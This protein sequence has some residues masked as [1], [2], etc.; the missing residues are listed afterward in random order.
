MLE[1]KIMI[2]KL[3]ELRQKKG[4]S[5]QALADA[6]GVSQQSVNKYENHN[7]EPDIHTLIALADYF[8]TSVDYLIGH[9]EV[10]RKIEETTACDL[11]KEEAALLEKWRQLNSKERVSILS[12]MDNYISKG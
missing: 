3:K 9:T 6:V 7:V 10:V 11:N 4:I 2:A 8:D 12:V 1:V 5:Q